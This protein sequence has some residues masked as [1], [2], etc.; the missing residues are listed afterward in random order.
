MA[1]ALRFVLARTT[2]TPQGQTSAHRCWRKLIPRIH[3]DRHKQA[4]ARVYY[5]LLAGTAMLERCKMVVDGKH[6]N[7]LLTGHAMPRMLVTGFNPRGSIND[8]PSGF[9]YPAA[10]AAINRGRND[11]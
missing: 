10:A 5:A 4:G 2:D 11:A 3:T 8:P 9:D 1:D 6:K 7:N